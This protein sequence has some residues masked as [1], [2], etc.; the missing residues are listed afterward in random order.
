[1]RS[2]IYHGGTIMSDHHSVQTEVSEGHYEAPAV[3]Q[4]EK[5]DAVAA[6]AVIV[7]AILTAIHF[8]YT[9]GLPAFLEHVL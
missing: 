9:G 7:V 3:T 5:A 1:M 6:F 4:D 8:V 2:L